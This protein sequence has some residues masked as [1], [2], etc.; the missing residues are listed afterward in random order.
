MRS[1]GGSRSSTRSRYPSMAARARALHALLGDPLRQRVDGDDAGELALVGV[2]VDPLPLGRG[3]LQREAGLLDLAVGQNVALVLLQR[4]ADPRL[5]EPGQR[6]ASRRVLEARFED[7][8]PAARGMGVDAGKPA[9]SPTHRVAAGARRREVAAVFIASAGGGRAG[10]PPCEAGLR[11]DRG[12]RR[13]KRLGACTSV[14]RRGG[15]RVV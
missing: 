15:H 12:D 14:V 6:D 3:H 13:R 10:R 9:A 1:E 11:H 2:L 4:A 7:D 5:V 8:H